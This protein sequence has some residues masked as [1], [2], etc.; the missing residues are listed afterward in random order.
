[1]NLSVD[2]EK[3]VCVVEATTHEIVLEHDELEVGASSAGMVHQ[4]AADAPALI[5]RVHED[6]TDL[7]TDER[8]EAD[9]TSICLGH[10]GF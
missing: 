1:M 7:V 4:G 9:D 6:A 10:R 2:L 8:Q 5:L 3:S